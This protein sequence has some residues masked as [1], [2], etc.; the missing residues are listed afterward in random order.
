M[1]TPA[2]PQALTGI[3]PVLWPHLPGL[4][5][6]TLARILST[7]P[8]YRDESAL[9][10]DELRTTIRSNFE[11]LLSHEPG[12]ED[13]PSSPPRMT[14]HRHAGVGI[15][16]ADVLSA[17]RIGFALLWDTITPLLT[18]EEEVGIGQ[19]IEA[20]TQMWWRA[21][22]FGQQVTEAYRDATTEILL[23][24]DRE[25]SAAVESLVTGTI[26]EQPALR[27]T[28]NRLG[29]P[30]T[31]H[32][33][34]AVAAAEQVGDE[35]LPGIV[36]DLHRVDVV[37]AWRLAP[38]QAVGVL[39]LPEPDPA[40]AIACVE[41]RATGAVGISPMFTHLE[42]TPRAY[43]LAGV[44]LRS[45]P[46]AGGLVRRFDETP[47]AILVAAAPDA[48]ADIAR[49]VLGSL[50]ELPDHDRDTVLD[51]FET[52]LHCAGS[53]SAAAA[54]MYCHP[55]TVRYRLRKLAE[56]TGRP[57][58]DPAATTELATALQ[59]WRLVGHATDHNG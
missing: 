43:Y 42:A 50:L 30:F 1:S 27:E 26:A 46:R 17:Y 2:D 59:A 49:N 28:A 5:D 37:S 31:G 35:P 4:V 51:T 14:G 6:R 23:R 44:A 15:P 12:T 54:K 58:E 34:V 21:D 47:I 55:N 40:R 13:P 45:R 10:R 33:L 41:A 22:H 53:V 36:E 48:A 19:V 16:L 57:T 29:I 20:A 39:S 52:W 11:Y 38:H 8:S 7:M 9:T 24:Q 3:A 25:R 32:F 18:A 56:H